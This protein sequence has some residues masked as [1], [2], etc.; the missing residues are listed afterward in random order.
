M[1]N[2]NWSTN[3]FNNYCIKPKMEATRKKV[4]KWICIN[5]VG[6]KF[7]RNVKY[8]CSKYL[9]HIPSLKDKPVRTITCQPPDAKHFNNMWKKNN[10]SSPPSPW[11][12]ERILQIEVLAAFV[13]KNLT[14][15]QLPGSEK[16]RKKVGKIGTSFSKK[17]TTILKRESTKLFFSDFR[18]SNLTSGCVPET[19][20]EAPHVQNGRR[21]TVSATLKPG[22]KGPA[23]S[24]Q[25]TQLKFLLWARSACTLLLTHVE[26]RY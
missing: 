2:I 23:G 6:L 25:K 15:F 8:I 9:L 21:L 14:I 18:F 3:N 13:K 1:K 26:N 4:V 17:K 24:G 19:T 12:V 20:W 11:R 22:P 5:T 7:R 10:P 16:K